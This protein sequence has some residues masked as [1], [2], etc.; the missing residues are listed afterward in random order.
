M[1]LTLE[2]KDK[3]D[4]I[5]QHTDGTRIKRIRHGLKNIIIRV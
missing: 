1:Q 4:E 2:V 3:S 5:C